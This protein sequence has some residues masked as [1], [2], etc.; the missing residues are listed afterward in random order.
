[1]RYG[2]K[3]D[4]E[5][6]ALCDFC[7]WLSVAVAAHAYDAEL[8]AFDR[9]C[10]LITLR[11]LTADRAA[12]NSANLIQDR[13]ADCRDCDLQGPRPCRDEES[14]KWLGC[15]W[16]N[17]KNKVAFVEQR[18]GEMASQYLEKYSDVKTNRRGSR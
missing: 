5:L 11:E 3:R 13:I 8:A 17:G 4:A 1:M 14:R 15:K 18:F 16:R 7:Q 2:H 6:D 10:R 12:L 9:K